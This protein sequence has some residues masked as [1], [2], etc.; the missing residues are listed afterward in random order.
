M[1]GKTAKEGAQILTPNDKRALYLFDK[2]FTFKTYN[3][4]IYTI[5][6]FIY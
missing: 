1:E 4:N 5:L 3:F 2:S 6:N